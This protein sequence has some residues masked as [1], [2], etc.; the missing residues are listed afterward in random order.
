MI[1]FHLVAPGYYF[2]MTKNDLK[3]SL[4][5]FL[6]LPKPQLVLFTS[7]IYWTS[8]SIIT[9]TNIMQAVDKIDEDGRNTVVSALHNTQVV[10]WRLETQ[11]GNSDFKSRL[12]FLLS[13]PES[14]IFV[15]KS[16]T[17]PYK[18]KSLHV[19][20]PSCLVFPN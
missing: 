12:P 8:K 15:L 11:R 1:N 19:R 3:D 17:S 7:F 18:R 5:S 16:G 2:K 14:N 20:N 13:H 4:N 9:F 6:P 10:L